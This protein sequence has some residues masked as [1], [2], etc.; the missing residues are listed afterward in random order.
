MDLLFSSNHKFCKIFFELLEFF[1][2]LS[3]GSVRTT[4]FNFSW[5][6]D[7]PIIILICEGIFK[8]KKQIS[9]KNGCTL[10][11]CLASGSRM[12]GRKEDRSCQKNNMAFW[13]FLLLLKWTYFINKTTNLVEIPDSVR[14]RLAL[15]QYKLDVFYTVLLLLFFLKKFREDQQFKL[16]R[17]FRLLYRREAGRGTTLST[18]YFA[19]K[20]VFKKLSQMSYTSNQILQRNIVLMMGSAAKIKIWKS[21]WRK[22]HTKKCG[23]KISSVAIHFKKFS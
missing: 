2:K 13:H 11:V 6:R 10:I 22:K 18:C 16:I 3:F 1:F 17:E 15:E 12:N 23:S 9:E 7:W 20:I 5:K 19:A 14:L 21:N 4:I 8:K